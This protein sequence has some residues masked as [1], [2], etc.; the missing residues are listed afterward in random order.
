VATL[1][2]TPLRELTGITLLKFRRALGLMAFFYVCAHFSVWLL[3][4]RQLDWPRILADLTKRPYIIIGFSA[5]LLLV[6]LALTSSNAAIRRFGG[7]GWRRLH[8]LIYPA[9]ALGA[10]HF[11]WLVKAW[12]IEPLAYAAAVAV[13]LL[14]RVVPRQQRVRLRFA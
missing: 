3:L 8:R 14:Y 11:V 13:L 12:P 9:A 4:D 6:P 5:F 2:V 1:C 10:V 7:A